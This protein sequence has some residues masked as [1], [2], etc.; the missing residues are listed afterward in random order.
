MP[1]L[2]KAT[3]GSFCKELV[4]QLEPLPN[5]LQS[6]ELTEDDYERLRRSEF[7][8][9]EMKAA[10]E[11]VRSMGPDAGFIARCKIL[12]EDF[13]PKMVQLME[14]PTTS[15]DVKVSLFDKFTDLARLKPSKQTQTDNTVKG[16]LVTF[17]FGAGMPGMPTSIDVTP[18]AI[19]EK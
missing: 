12:S 16:P 4:L 14:A 17:N 15:P 8:Q 10:V 9:N 11:E 6:W 19:E 2:T 7:F 1:T 13:L 3:L 5:F 18:K